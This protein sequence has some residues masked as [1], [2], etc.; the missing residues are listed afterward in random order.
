MCIYRFRR[1][2][3]V[4]NRA[5]VSGKLPDGSI[6]YFTIREMARIQGFPDE[7]VFHPVW[8]HAVAELG[9]AC[10]PP[11][12]HRWLQQ[13]RFPSGASGHEQELDAAAARAVGGASRQLPQ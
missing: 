5:T 7:Y 2:E 11:L 12:A 6:R 4:S 9:N 10:P 3:G 1:S 13:F 8:S